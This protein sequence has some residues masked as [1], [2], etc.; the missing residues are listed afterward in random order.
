M[1]KRIAAIAL[2]LCLLLAMGSAALAADIMPL[3]DSCSVCRPY[4][5]VSGN[6]A[7]CMLDVRAVNGGDRIIATVTLQKEN[8]RGNYTNV[9]SW[10][11]LSGTGSLHFAD[12]YGV[13]AGASYRLK[14]EV[15]VSGSNGTEN[16]TEYAY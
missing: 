6:T 3:W 13:T 2:S 4:L 7:N 11:G 8:S 5:S 12:S 15:K 16:I 10:S 14:A 1:R 9:K